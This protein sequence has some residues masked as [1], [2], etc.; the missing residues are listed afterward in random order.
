MADLKELA[1]KIR[2]ME[3]KQ[4]KPCRYGYR[5]IRPKLNKTL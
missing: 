4:Y 5:N 2:R 3:A 1:E